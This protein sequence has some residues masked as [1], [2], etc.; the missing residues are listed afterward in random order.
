MFSQINLFEKSTNSLKVCKFSGAQMPSW[1]VFCLGRGQPALEVYVMQIFLQN[2]RFKI[3]L[4]E[5][6]ERVAH[7]ARINQ[8]Q[9]NAIKEP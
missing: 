5:K 3:K 8:L 2:Y 6:I 9:L 1:E 4:S 7:N